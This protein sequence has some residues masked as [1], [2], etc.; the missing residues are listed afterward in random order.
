MDIDDAFRLVTPQTEL[1]ASDPSECIRVELEAMGQI[2]LSFTILPFFGS[3]S[4]RQVQTE[5]DV[6]YVL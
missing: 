4:L 1:M 5:L 3:A 6:E 2:C